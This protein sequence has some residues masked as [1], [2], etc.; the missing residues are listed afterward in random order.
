M[1]SG[2]RRSLIGEHSSP[3]ARRE[4]RQEG[5]P[6][7]G[8]TAT[9]ASTEDLTLLPRQRQSFGPPGQGA[10]AAPGAQAGQA[11][12]RA[13]HR[14]SALADSQGARRLSRNKRLGPRSPSYRAGPRTPARGR[15][16]VG[17]RHGRLAAR[18]SA[19]G[20]EVGENPRGM[21]DHHRVREVSDPC[22]TIGACGSLSCRDLGSRGCYASLVRTAAATDPQFR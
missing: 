14:Y 20:T 13:R 22:S 5:V 3:G 1:S 6:L 17:W 15:R 4:S 18:K 19:G 12:P 11:G 7:R 10:T 8:S 21:S 2:P 16:P 9:A